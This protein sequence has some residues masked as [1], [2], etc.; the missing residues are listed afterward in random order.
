MEAHARISFYG[1]SE[2]AVELPWISHTGEE[3]AQAAEIKLFCFYSSQALADLG[4]N[5]YTDELASYVQGVSW[6]GD[7][8]IASSTAWDS[9]SWGDRSIGEVAHVNADASREAKP[10]FEVT[11]THDDQPSSLFFDL[12]RQS[13]WRLTMRKMVGTGRAGR[14]QFAATVPAL[15]QALAAR[16]GSNPEYQGKLFASCRAI[17]FAYSVDLLKLPIAWTYVA[18]DATAFGRERRRPGFLDLSSI[19]DFRPKNLHDQ[20]WMERQIDAGRRSLAEIPTDEFPFAHI[21]LLDQ[22]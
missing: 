12:N 5:Y 8:W 10:F 3:L 9:S 11:L 19:T 14:A 7:E 18:A 16:R 20:M 22:A 17:C 15:L 4:R 2:V 21:D 1:R 6:P 13:D